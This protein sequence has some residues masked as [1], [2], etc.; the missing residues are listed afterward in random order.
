MSKIEKLRDKFY[1]KPIPNDVTFDEVV[2]LAKSYG[3]IIES[4]GNHTKVVYKNKELGL[5]RVIP[6]PKHGKTIG[7]VYVKELKELF[8]AIEEVRK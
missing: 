2:T 4:G 5:Y 7:E 3:C 6:V 8:D 1:K